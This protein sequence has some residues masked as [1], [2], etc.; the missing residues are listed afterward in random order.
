MM[1]PPQAIETPTG[2]AASAFDLLRD[3][4][5]DAMSI[6]SVDNKM[7]SGTVIR[8]PS[9]GGT[10]HQVNQKKYSKQSSPTEL[11]QEIIEDEDGWLNDATTYQK[12]PETDV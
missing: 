12:G 6:A 9:G 8:F 5:W 2:I 1:P 11:L 7:D 4:K 10:F 3:D